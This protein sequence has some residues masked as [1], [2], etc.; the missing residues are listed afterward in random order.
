MTDLDIEILIKSYLGDQEV[1]K[2]LIE[3]FRGFW[4]DAYDEGYNDGYKDCD[5]T[6]YE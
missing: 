1:P 6:Y 5:L 4:T 2:E 3:E